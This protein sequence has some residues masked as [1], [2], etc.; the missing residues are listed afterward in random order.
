MTILETVVRSIAATSALILAVALSRAAMAR[1]EGR[2]FGTCLCVGVAAYTALTGIPLT[3]AVLVSALGAVFS[4]GIPFFFWGLSRSVMD[5][6]FRLA[7]QAAI[8]GAVLIGITVFIAMRPFEGALG[9]AIA[10][11]S[12]LGIA[13]VIAALVDVLR[14]WRADMVESR[15]RLRLI[16]LLVAGGYSIGVLVTELILRTEAPGSTLELLNVILLAVLLLGLACFTLSLSPTAHA[17]FGWT[18][19]MAPSPTEPA[20]VL[21]ND[22][23]GS[24]IS[25]LEHLMTSGAGYRDPQLTVASLA[26]RIGVSERKLR[27]LINQ[28]LGHRNFASFVNSFRLEEIRRRLDDARHDHLPILTLALDAGFGSVVAFNRAFKAKHGV[29]PSEYR[30]KRPGQT[31]QS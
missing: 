14:G 13:F 31:L 23:E 29:T 19:A 15:R 6:D 10:S 18:A 28:R 9:F 2:V 11:H 8:A 1:L 5:D 7:P 24:L 25:K 21:A 4:G 12:L 16:V 26:A 27:E 30:A 20:Q 3:G 17:A 22:P